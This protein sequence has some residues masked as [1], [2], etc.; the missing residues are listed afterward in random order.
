MRTY[1][2]SPMFEDT[3]HVTHGQKTGDI[4][5]NN[6]I[7]KFKIGFNLSTETTS[8]GSFPLTVFVTSSQEEADKRRREENSI[9]RLCPL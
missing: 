7:Q 4:F 6:L 5:R 9:R 1:Y 2:R 8:L 3:Y